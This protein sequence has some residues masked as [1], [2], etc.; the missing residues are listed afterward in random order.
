MGNVNGKS[1]RAVEPVRASKPSLRRYTVPFDASVRC[2]QEIE[3]SEPNLVQI[4]GARAQ[5]EHSHT[6]LGY[7]ESAFR[8][9]GVVDPQLYNIEVRLLIDDIK[10]IKGIVSWIGPYAPLPLLR[11]QL[12]WFLN[13]RMSQYELQD[14]EEGWWC[15]LRAGVGSLRASYPRLNDFPLKH[16]KPAWMTYEET[17]LDPAA[18]EP[19]TA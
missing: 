18:Q 9:A 15:L 14:E 11:H 13:D 6:W 5:I 8:D 7:L 17:V 3:G 4:S 12:D 10:D 16:Y 1:T 2:L 19:V